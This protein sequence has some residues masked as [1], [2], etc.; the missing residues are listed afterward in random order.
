MSVIWCVLVRV[1]CVCDV[2]SVL[3]VG[4]C[5]LRG[6]C[7]VCLVCCVVSGVCRVLRVVWSLLSVVCWLLRIV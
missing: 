2:S 4:C 5:E 7:A 3:C 1:C 6:V